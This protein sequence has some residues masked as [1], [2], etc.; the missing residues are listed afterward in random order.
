[1]HAFV[2]SVEIYSFFPFW[3]QRISLIVEEARKLIRRVLR[4]RQ[5][6]PTFYKP[7]DH[8]VNSSSGKRSLSD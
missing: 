5:P 1:M 6:H 8:Q 4:L 7:I 3:N 2:P